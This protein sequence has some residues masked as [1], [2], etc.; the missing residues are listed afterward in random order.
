M[1][2]VTSVGATEM[3]IVWS[4]GI[5]ATAIAVL[6]P[7]GCVRIA[8]CQEYPSICL[9][10]GKGAARDSYTAHDADMDY[11]SAVRP[12]IEGLEA[13]YATANNQL[14]SATRH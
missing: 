14:T 12:F 6:P 7:Y 1:L 2:F 3:V 13:S 9:M 8:L 10:L 11:Q 4:W 5:Q